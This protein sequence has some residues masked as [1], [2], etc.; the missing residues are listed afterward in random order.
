MGRGAADSK[1]GAQRGLLGS[2]IPS[3][4]TFAAGNSACQRSQRSQQ[5]AEETG[6][7][8]GRGSASAESCS[9]SY[10]NEFYTLLLTQSELGRREEVELQKGV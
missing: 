6:H 4:P 10:I 3:L 5:D 7:R 2:P 1:P 9:G 8:R